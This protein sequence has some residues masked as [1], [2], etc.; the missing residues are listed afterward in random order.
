MSI[1]NQ[2]NILKSISALEGE[3]LALLN[4]SADFDGSVEVEPGITRSSEQLD[5]E[6][7]AVT[8]TLDNIFG[9]GQALWDAVQRL[10][11]DV[12]DSQVQAQQLISEA[13]GLVRDVEATAA[14]RSAVESILSDPNREA[15]MAVNE[16]RLQLIDSVQAEYPLDVTAQ[17]MSAAESLVQEA[18][19]TAGE[20]YGQA[21]EGQT[22]SDGIAYRSQVAK[23]NA[24]GAATAAGTAYTAATTYKVCWDLYCCPVLKFGG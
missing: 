2:T 22:I 15:E 5:Q 23:Q 7:G 6:L 3:I 9:Q 10:Y 14:Q 21:L 17:N 19:G 18:N 13:D 16:Q 24:T 12:L 1:Q 4:T 11:Q 8:G 20:A